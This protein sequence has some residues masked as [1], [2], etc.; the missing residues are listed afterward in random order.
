MDMKQY[1]LT[2]A[3]WRLG[4]GLDGERRSIGEKKET[5]IVEAD[6]GAARFAKARFLLDGAVIL[7]D[8]TV[9]PRSEISFTQVMSL[10][11]VQLLAAFTEPDSYIL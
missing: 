2:Y 8:K 3:Q 1:R 9:Y 11:P 6:E 4:E 7:P 10:Q 5:I